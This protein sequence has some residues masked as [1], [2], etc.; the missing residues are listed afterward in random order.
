MDPKGLTY[1]DYQHKIDGYKEIFMDQGKPKVKTFNGIN[2]RTLLFIYSKNDPPNEYKDF[3]VNSVEEIFKK[4][5][6]AL[7]ENHS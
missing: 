3:V 4:V 5:K 1:T 6:I 2:V 7:T